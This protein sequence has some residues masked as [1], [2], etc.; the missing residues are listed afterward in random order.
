MRIRE[1]SFEK[2]EDPKLESSSTP[3]FATNSRQYFSFYISC[4]L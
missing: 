2:K 1:T 3:I 4:K